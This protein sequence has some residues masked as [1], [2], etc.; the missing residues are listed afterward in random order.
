[1]K[2]ILK[3][4]ILKKMKSRIIRLVRQFLS[5]KTKCSTFE[6]ILIKTFDKRSFFFRQ[7][8]SKFHFDDF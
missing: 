4:N 1:M 6:K 5:Q 7:T 2:R 8:K 3:K